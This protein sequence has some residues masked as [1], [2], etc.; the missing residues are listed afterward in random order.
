MKIIYILLFLP[1]IVAGQQLVGSSGATHVGDLIWSFSLGEIAVSEYQSE[2]LDLQEGVQQSF[3]FST[4]VQVQDKVHTSVFPNPAG[5]YLNVEIEDFS[6]ISH[7][8][9]IDYRGVS[10]IKEKWGASQT[11]QLDI[12]ALHPGGYHLMI[13]RKNNQ[14]GFITPFIKSN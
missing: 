14:L 11:Q 1:T 8:H 9:I 6:A 5:R 3:D 13:F 7:V 4:A 10:L 2:T 12:G